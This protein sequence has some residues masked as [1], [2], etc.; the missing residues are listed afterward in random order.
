MADQTNPLDANSR[1]GL[2]AVSSTDGKTIVRLWADPITHRLLTD[3]AGGGSGTVTSVSVVTANGFAGTVANATTTPAITL[4]T[5]ITGILK[6]NGTAISAGVAGDV[7]SILP[8]QSGHSGQF[9]TTNG[10][11]SSWAAGGST[12]PASPDTAVQFNNSGSFGGS[13]NFEWDNMGTNLYLSGNVSIAPH[14]NSSGNGDNLFIGSGNSTFTDGVGGNMDVFAGSGNGAGPGGNVLIDGGD[15][16]VTGDGGYIQIRPGA[17]DT[18]G[19]VKIV[20]AGSSTSVVVYLGAEND[21][22]NILGP[23]AVT[24]DLDGGSLLVGGGMGNGVGHGGN[25]NL[26]GG[27]GGATG[28]GGTVN[29]FAGSGGGSGIG[30]LVEISSGQGGTTGN[31]GSIDIFA[32]SGGAT[33]GNGGDL[34]LTAGNTPG[35][36]T[37]GHVSIADPTS[38]ISAIFD[39]TLLASSNKTFTFPN[40]SGTFALVGAGGA[41]YQSATFVVSPNSGEGDYTDIQTAIDNLPAG[42]GLIFVRAGV[43]TLAASINIKQDNTVIIGEGRATEI[44]F[45]KA[46]VTP[47]IKFNATDFENCR[48]ES[49]ALIQTNA[50]AGGVGISCGDQPFLRINDV[51][52]DKCATGIDINDTGNLSFYGTYSNLVIEECT[53]AAISLRGNPV[54]DNTFSQIRTLGAA[55]S[56]GLDLQKGNGNTFISFNSE[57]ASTT[58]TTGVKIANDTSCYSNS[59][60]GVYVEGNATGIS[61]VGSN[62]A[63]NAFWGGE[64]TG[65]TADISDSGTNTKLMGI[66]LTSGARNALGSFTTTLITPAANDGAALGTTALQFSDLFLASGGVI[67]WANG[68]VTLTQSSGILTQNNGELRITSANVGTNADSVPTLSSTSTL[69]NKTLTSPTIQT[70]P[71][72]A[73]ATNLKFTVPSSDPSATGITTNE[74]NSGYSSTAIGDLVYLDSSA[75]WQKADADASAATYSSMLGIALSVAAS[76]APVNVLLQGFFYGAT[77]LPTLTIGAPVYMSATAGAMT[78]T[79]PVT[80]DSA[81]RIVGYG[82]HADKLWFSP[83]NDWIT[84]V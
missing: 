60:I 4:S 40:A 27:D 44:D 35:T 52:I 70:S 62:A 2:T 75:T 53:T 79:A 3:A 19:T 16:G 34:T 56:I 69:T 36:G 64:A 5:T 49:L 83:S 45:D 20:P 76:A 68:N 38:S 47:A 10:T 28:N 32:G 77:A 1:Q 84:H 81:T 73:A 24:T 39:T 29:V 26:T 31:G 67:N 25:A 18:D 15:G 54:N 33:S 43:Y 72:L 66:A 46:S 17:G 14:D 21:G 65:N 37:D 58:G 82:I 11:N 9:L 74:F 50:T 7:D 42:G 8:T 13:A 61:I 48:I 30:G 51:L 55:N 12:S 80:T 23:D 63:N 57:P 6:G 78:Q 71:V 41:Q 59:F 22:S